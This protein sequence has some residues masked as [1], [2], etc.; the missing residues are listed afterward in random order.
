MLQLLMC[1]I[2]IHLL[3]QPYIVDYY[4]S[5]NFFFTEMNFQANVNLVMVSKQKK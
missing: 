2:I 3:D 4:N 5:F 1:H